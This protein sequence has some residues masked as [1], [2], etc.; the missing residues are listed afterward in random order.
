MKIKELLRE[1][2]N[3]TQGEAARDADGHRVTA[4]SPSAV[5]FC[6]IGA[7]SKCYGFGNHYKIVDDL[8]WELGMRPSAWNDNRDRTHAEVLALVEKLDI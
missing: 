6:I 4:N 8:F 1:P 3:W 5:C 7:A 2:K